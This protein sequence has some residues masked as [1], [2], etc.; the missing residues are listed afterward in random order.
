MHNRYLRT[1]HLELRNHKYRFITNK[2]SVQRHFVV[3][4]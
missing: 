1:I 2:M 4:L 3:N